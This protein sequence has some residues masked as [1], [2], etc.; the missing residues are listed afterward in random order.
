MLRIYADVEALWL[1][2]AASAKNASWAGG[3]GGV[4]KPMSL[5][6]IQQEEARVEVCCLHELM[7]W[8]GGKKRVGEGVCETEMMGAVVWY[9]PWCGRFR[10]VW[11]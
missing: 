9:A 6:E 10:V 4:K 7:V 11:W 2:A 8:E 3:A 5:A 1:Q